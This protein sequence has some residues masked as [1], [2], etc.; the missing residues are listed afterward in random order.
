MVGTRQLILSAGVELW[1]KDPC[2]VTVRR[3]AD[4]LGLSY[5]AILYHFA[6]VAELRAAIAAHAVE[7]GN[8]AVIVQLIAVKH[9]AIARMHYIDRQAHLSVFNRFV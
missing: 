3:I 1:A 6:T 5:H 8:S 7:V 4:A 9:P 2:E